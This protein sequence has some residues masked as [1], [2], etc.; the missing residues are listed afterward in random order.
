METRIDGRAFVEGAED[1]NFFKDA[2]FS[3]GAS[4]NLAKLAKGIACPAGKLL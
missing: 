4:V 1:R 3:F 2:G